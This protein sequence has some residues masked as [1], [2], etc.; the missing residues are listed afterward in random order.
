MSNSNV[1]TNLSSNKLEKKNNYQ[2]GAL[3]P[4]ESISPYQ[5]QGAF[6]EWNAPSCD[7]LLAFGYGKKYLFFVSHLHQE[8]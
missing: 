1:K 4:S 6:L 2:K 3:V 7:A 5:I 8:K